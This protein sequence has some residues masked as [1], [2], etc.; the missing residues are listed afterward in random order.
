VKWKWLKPGD[1]LIYYALISKMGEQQ[2]LTAAEEQLLQR[3]DVKLTEL[4]MTERSVEMTPAALCNRMVASP[5]I[6]S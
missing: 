4:G 6:A 2:S 5:K 1:I 3:L